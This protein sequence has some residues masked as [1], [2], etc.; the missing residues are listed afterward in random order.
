MRFAETSWSGPSIAESQYLVRPSS[1]CMTQRLR[2]LSSYLPG[3]LLLLALLAWTEPGATLPP[4]TTEGGYAVSFFDPTQK[5]ADGEPLRPDPAA[6]DRD[7][8]LLAGIT[9]RIRTYE[10]SR[11]PELPALA[12]QHGLQLYLGVWLSRDLARNERELRAGAHA[13]HE[14]PVTALIV[15]NEVLLRKEL[16]PSL[17]KLTL[18]RARLLAKVPVSTAEYAQTWLD[19]PDLV[20][21]V[22]FLTVHLLPYWQGVDIDGAVNHAIADLDRLRATF[23]GKPVVVGEVGWPS[24]GQ[25]LGFAVP[26][27]RHQARF[28]KAFA[29]AMRERDRP[30]PWFWIEAFDQPWKL[31]SEGSVGPHWGHFDAQ[32]QRKFAATHALLHPPYWH[33]AL[34]AVL[35]FTAVLWAAQALYPRWTVRQSLCFGGISAVVLVL[36]ASASSEWSA[37]AS[38]WPLPFLLLFALIVLRQVAEAIESP[39]ERVPLRPPALPPRARV[40]LQVAAAAEAPAV[41]ERSLSSMAAVSHVLQRIL[42][43]NNVADASY[44]AAVARRC[45]ELQIDFHWLPECPGHKA[46]A[47]NWALDHSGDSDWIGI[48]DADYRLDPRWIESVGH[49]LDD[50]TIDVIQLPQCHEAAEDRWAQAQSDEYDSFFRLAMPARADGAA[51]VM[52]GTMVLIRRHWLQQHRW[53]TTCIVEDAELGLRL[54]ASGARM[55]YLQQPMGWGLLPDRAAAWHRQRHR[56][57][58]GATQILRLH[59]GALFGPSR[60]GATQ[61][62]HWFAGWLPWF[63]HALHLAFALA[64]LLWSISAILL[65]KQI[66]LPGV[67][68][69]LPVFAL[70]G[71]QIVAGLLALRQRVCASWIDSLRCAWVSAALGSTI[72]LALWSGLWRRRRPFDATRIAP[73]NSRG[74]LRWPASLVV[75]LLGSAIAIAMAWDGPTPMAIVWCSLVILFA[76]PYLATV[77][78]WRR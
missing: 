19:H 61:R 1:P 73:P 52:Q 18:Q 26:S 2:R 4:L 17:L 5:A 38:I 43:L 72:A 56:W 40:V 8:R 21:A 66:D 59:A 35:L 64:A 11:L 60:L 39:R 6:L 23:P 12:K 54:S 14:G 10:A 55:V 7:L 41:L 69:L 71:V 24:H 37:G 9:S 31:N 20:D 57:A 62:L 36:I 22:D 44:S 49:W 28:V 50:P 33:R 51:L 78:L 3:V 27:P 74:Y 34:A 77:L 53:D 32:R 68:W 63:G 45:R 58:F 30:E 47:L 65:P 16:S 29:A 75:L 67:A 76:L 42:V 25:R 13:A 48:F 70:L 15:G 46:Q